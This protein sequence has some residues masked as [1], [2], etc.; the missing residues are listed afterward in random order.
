[1]ATQNWGELAAAAGEVTAFEPIPNNDY[2]F[3]VSKCEF[4]PTSQG[5]A[6]WKLQCQVQ[7]GPYAKRLV[8]DNLVLS[9]ESSMALG[10]FWHTLAAL[11]IPKA[12]VVENKPSNEQLEQMMVGR[13]F[14]AK[15]GQKTYQGKAGNEI[16]EYY[17]PMG[18]AAPA[19]APTTAAAA[20]PAPAASVPDVTTTE[21]VA[22]AE[23]VAAP[24]PPF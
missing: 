22:E 12:W 24:A 3:V 13:P 8:F 23:T 16:K 6:M 11:G 17:L 4:K 18:A 14:R 2:D 1:M 15:V 20:A 9:P 7:N 19:A 21:S 5:K 10:F